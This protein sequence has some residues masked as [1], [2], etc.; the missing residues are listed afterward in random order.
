MRVFIWYS[1]DWLTFLRKT[2]YEM[3]LY[4]LMHYFKCYL[5]IY[6][7]IYRANN[8]DVI[9]T[10]GQRNRVSTSSVIFNMDMFTITRG[11]KVVCIIR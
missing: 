8:N 10:D 11:E 9:S 6:I 2:Y 7:Y 4:L 5:Y 3:I 1:I